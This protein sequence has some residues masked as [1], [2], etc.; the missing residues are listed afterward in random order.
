MNFRRFALSLAA[1]MVLVSLAAAASVSSPD[2]HV[3]VEIAVADGRLTYSLS[4]DGP[5]LLDDSP[6]GLVT[7]AGDFSH[8]LRLVDTSPVTP[9]HSEYD[10]D[11]GKRSH[12]TYDANRAVVT[13][14]RRGGSAVVAGG[15]GFERRPR[16]R[17]PVARLSG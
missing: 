10:L 5:P 1:A 13:V 9:V 2:G 8:G 11:N 4:L 17:L 12:A 3:T 16:A 14:G 15:A 6:L 7:S